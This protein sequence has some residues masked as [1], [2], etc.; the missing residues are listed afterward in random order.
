MPVPE[1]I[2]ENAEDIRALKPDAP[3]FQINVASWQNHF[4]E[5]AEVMQLVKEFDDGKFRRGI[6]RPQVVALAPKGE[7]PSFAELR[8][9]FV[10]TMMWGYGPAGY[11]PWRTC[12]AL[13][14]PRIETALPDAYRRI[15]NHELEAARRGFAVN[16][17]GLSFSTK[18]FYFIGRAHNIRPPLPLILD[19]RVIGNLCHYAPELADTIASCQRNDNDEVVS[20]YVYSNGYL[21]YMNTLNDWAKKMNVKPDQ[22]EFFL[23]EG[24]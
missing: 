13:H 23:W 8:P 7:E 21:L 12:K 1:S 16:W 20:F 14:D 2:Q 24:D 19:M 17:C 3:R 5:D 10:A 18:F 11:G 9:L 6:S 4:A 15:L 22:L